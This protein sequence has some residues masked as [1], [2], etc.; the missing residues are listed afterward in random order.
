MAPFTLCFLDHVIAGE[1]E[2]FETKQWLA[3]EF[4][5]SDDV[6]ACEHESFETKQ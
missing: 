5:C 3:S 2:S 1:H 6:A 4:V